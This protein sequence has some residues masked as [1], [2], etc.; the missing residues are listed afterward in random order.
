VALAALVCVITVYTAFMTFNHVLDQRN[1]RRHAWLMITGLF[2]ATGIWATHFVAMLAYDSGFVI[3]Y[4]PRLT[5]LSFIVAVISTTAGFWILAQARRRMG[6]AATA[7][8]TRTES[9]AAELQD[10]IERELVPAGSQE[11]GIFLPSMSGRHLALLAGGIAGAGI[12]LMHFTGMRA[13]QLAGHIEWDH[14]LTAAALAMGILFGALALRVHVSSRRRLAVWAAPLLLVIAIVSMHFTAM[15]AVTIVPDPTMP[16]PVAMFDTTTFAMALAAVTI[17]VMFAGFSAA[18][19][20]TSVQNRRLSLELAAK[21]TELRDAQEEMLRRGRMAQLGNLTATVAHELRNPLGAIRTSAFLLDRKLKGKNL[22]IDGQVERITSGVLRCDSIITQLLDFARAA[23]LKLSDHEIDAWIATLVEEEAQK[24]PEAVTIECHLGL[25]DLRVAFEAD[26][27]QR[28]II[29]LLSN[30]SEAM[31]GKGNDP[32]KFTT[33]D[34]RIRIETRRSD[35]GIEIAVSDNGPGI[36]RDVIQ[37][38]REPLFT[39]KSFGTGLG[40]PAVDKIM[41]LHGGGMDIESRHGA[42]STFIIWLPERTA[43]TGERLAA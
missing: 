15:G 25:D 29:N 1:P 26:R 5:A 35:R 9:S 38:I 28:A 32:T 36:T 40:L 20:E 33:R 4:E 39:T 24:L 13:V 41:D 27:L 14:R 42:G 16:Q 12:S 8:E 10:R 22:G 11:R 30:A 23:P 21:L 18:L 3:T 37:R 34:P 43:A 19:I 17:G 2:A 7:E 31:V 6:T